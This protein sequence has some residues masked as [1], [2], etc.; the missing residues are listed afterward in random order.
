M[1]TEITQMISSLL[2]D[3][4][5]AHLEYFIHLSLMFFDRN[6]PEH[7]PDLISVWAFSDGSVD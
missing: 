2:T 5:S 4:K 1:S 3:S 6:E 7:C